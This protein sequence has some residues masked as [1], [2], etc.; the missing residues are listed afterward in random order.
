MF[1][2]SKEQLAILNFL[3]Y[4]NY[5]KDYLSRAKYLIMKV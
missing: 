5:A 4:S 3:G 2:I 1:K